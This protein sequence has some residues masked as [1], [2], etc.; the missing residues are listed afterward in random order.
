[1]FAIV[2]IL[3]MLFVPA[4]VLFVVIYAVVLGGEGLIIR[5]RKKKYR[6]GMEKVK[7]WRR[8]IEKEPLPLASSTIRATQTGSSTSGTPTTNRNL[9]TTKRSVLE[10]RHSG[11]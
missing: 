11:W 5:H 4:A 9:L 3:C 6:E 1:M 8:E 10:Q 2:A 7:E